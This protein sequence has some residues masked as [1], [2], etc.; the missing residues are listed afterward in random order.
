MSVLFQAF[1]I[2]ATQFEN[3]TAIISGEQKTSYQSLL[4]TAELWSDKLNSVGISS[5]LKVGFLTEEALHTAALSLAVAKISATCVP[6]NPQLTATQLV[7]GW[8]ATDVNIVV[9][10]PEFSHKVKQCRD[11]LGENTIEFIAVENFP[12]IANQNTKIEQNSSSEITQLQKDNK[13]FIITLSSG[14]TG[15]PKP[16]S[17]SQQCK[18]LRAQQSWQL[19][20]ITPDD[21]ILC[22]SP[23]FHSLGQR[24]FFVPLLLGATLVQ[25][26]QFTPQSWIAAVEQF[27]ISKVISVSSHL[28][29]LKDE[30]LS[31][32]KQLCSLK[33]IVTSSAPID[34]HFKKQLFD[35]IGCDFHEMY[36]ATEI[37][38]ATNL[39]P[40][41]SEQKHSTVGSPCPNVS[42]K[43]LAS[44]KSELPF[45]QIGEIA[46]KSL[47]VFNEYYQQEE[48]TEA[49][50]QQE[51]FLTGDLGK[52]GSDGFL[53]YVGRK[54]DI[55][56]SGGINVY[57]KDIETALTK[58]IS[59]REIA[60][61]GVEDSFLGEVIIAICVLE[62]INTANSHTNTDAFADTVKTVERE[63]RRIANKN[64]APFQRP[65]KYFFKQ[66]L[67]LTASG[68]ISKLELRNQYNELKEDWSAPLRAMLYR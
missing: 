38:T 46:V 39:Y 23:F 40:Q 8:L 52:L 34:N 11:L 66:S 57:P 64:L 67:P 26:K 44:N 28:Y 22:A 33:T 68:K 16:I 60:V 36:G 21:I 12:T 37:A 48:L 27:K 42:I 49:A 31:N 35:T 29:A 3:K 4:N 17:I 10:E 51:Y 5:E 19:Y 30:L 50:F 59:L 53:S 61:I 65:L 9:F 24:L 41:F 62:G 47:L 18:L 55:I 20:N 45:G 14:S 58:H 15:S 1:K 2:T 54:K 13:H 25:L 32:A 6:T 7:E 63:L 43:I 56:I